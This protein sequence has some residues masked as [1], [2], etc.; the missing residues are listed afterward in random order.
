MDGD[1]R[2]E[3]LTIEKRIKYPAD[4]KMTVKGKYRAA[5]IV[6]SGVRADTVIGTDEITITLPQI[7]GY[8]ASAF[9]RE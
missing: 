2:G 3:A 5:I 9:T 7:E 4:A 1:R 6:L 8:M